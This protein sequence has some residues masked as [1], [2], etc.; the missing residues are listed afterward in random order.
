MIKFLIGGTPCTSWSCS[1]TRGRETTPAGI[2]WEHFR[3]FVVAKEKWRP[4]FILYE[5]NKSVAKPIKEAISKELGLPLQHINSALVSAQN[6]ERFYA[7]NFGDVP[8]PKDRG[9][10][11]EDILESGIPFRGEKSGC[12]DANYYRGGNLSSFEKQSGKRLM[13]AEPVRVG[14]V[15]K[16][17]QGERIYSISGKSVCLSANG[18]GWGSRTGMYAI[19]VNTTKDGK[20]QCIRASAWRD[21]IRNMV[22][23]D[24]DRRTCVAI[25]AK[26][27]VFGDKKVYE[28]KGGFIEIKGKTYPIKLDDGFYH[29]R[30]LSVVEAARLQ[31]LPDNFC[32]AVSN[33]RAYAGLGAGWT[34]EI[35]IHLLSYALKNVPKDEEIV[36]LSLYDGIGTG[37]YC[38]D[39][40]GYNKNLR[41]YAYEID[42]YSIKISQSNYPDSIIQCGD[43]FQVRD[44]EWRI[45]L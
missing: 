31:T 14:S 34:A 6:R 3:N 22:G 5:N 41:Y 15:N 42:P 25:P 44:D 23:N 35:I 27:S 29:I 7:H 40:L 37:R 32:R 17:G 45:P 9:I 39:K 18:G 4:D 12:L 10:L 28:V 36:V 2:G 33:S 13:V 24:V 20:A 43:A 11:L 26:E 8:L 21:G 16:G 30:K 1:C 19:P 38:F